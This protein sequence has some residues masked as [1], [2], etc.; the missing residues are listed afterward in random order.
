MRFIFKTTYQQ[1]IRMYRH[2]GDIFWYGLLMLALLVAPAVLDVYY[3]GE[4]TLMAIFAIAGV[5]LMLLTGY[6]G[7]ISLGHAAFFGVGAYTEA[8]LIEAGWP[9]LLSF[10]TAGLLAGAVGV[11]IG[12]PALR[13]T[14]LYL[15]IATLAFAFI[16]EEVLARWESVTHGYEGMPVGDISLL[17]MEIDMDIKN[18]EDYRNY[19]VTTQKAQDVLGAKFNGSIESILAELAE[20]FP[21]GFDFDQDEFY[22]IRVFEKLFKDAN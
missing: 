5:G 21:E 9:F 2:G 3:I 11:A 8:V 19:K 12:L 6:T 22:N 15:A 4:L 7:Q 13:L 14:G 20:N 17:G 16:V 18:I 10:P 1:D